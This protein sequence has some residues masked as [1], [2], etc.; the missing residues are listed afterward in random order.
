MD[1]ICDDTCLAW[2]APPIRWTGVDLWYW[3]DMEA[4]LEI[5]DKLRCVSDVANLC[6]ELEEHLAVLARYGQHQ[7]IR[8]WAAS[9]VWDR[10]SAHSWPPGY[11]RADDCDACQEYARRLRWTL[12]ELADEVQRWTEEFENA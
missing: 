5:E 1:H 3:L 6:V 2:D 8:E 9:R 4:Y 11:D 12:C 7:A 10:L